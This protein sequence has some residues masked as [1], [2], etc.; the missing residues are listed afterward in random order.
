MWDKV[1]KSGSGQTRKVKYSSSSYSVSISETTLSTLKVRIKTLNF[2]TSATSQKRQRNNLKRSSKKKVETDKDFNK[3]MNNVTFL[4]KCFLS[5]SPSAKKKKPKLLNKS[6]KT[7]KA[8]I[9]AAEK[10]RK[11][12]QTWHWH[13]QH[14][15]VS[16]HLISFSFFR[17]KCLNSDTLINFFLCL[18]SFYQ[19]KLEEALKA[20]ELLVQQHPQSPRARYGKAQVVQWYCS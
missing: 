15:I 6:D 8:E 5:L 18:F 9:D 2:I 7:I 17:Q 16:L 10:L 14:F 3:Q 11:K 1:L 13:L 12:V 19:G 20:F 4:L